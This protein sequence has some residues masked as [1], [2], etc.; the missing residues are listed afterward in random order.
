MQRNK[1]EKND[2]TIH[3][4]ARLAGVSSA[5]VSRYLNGGSLSAEKRAIIH[6]V[7]ESTGY[8]PD[9]T[10]Q[11]MRT[12]RVNQIGL[13][14]PRF[15]SSEV[16]QIMTGAANVLMQQGYFALMAGSA[17]EKDGEQGCVERMQRNHVAGILL[18]SPYASPEHESVYRSCRLPLV[19]VGQSLTDIATVRS[20]ER[21][22]ARELAERMLAAGRRSIAYIG[23]SERGNVSNENRRLG[24]QDALTAAGLD[25]AHMP[26]ISCGY[27]SYEEG[28][29][30]MELLLA[31]CPELDGVICSADPVALGAMRVL[32]AAGHAIGETVGLAGMGDSWANQAAE[33]PLASVKFYH[34][35]LGAEAANMLI[36][37]IESTDEEV[38]ARQ[39]TLGYTIVER[40]SL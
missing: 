32:K 37:Q 18:I 2:M 1:H 4:I 16:V 23:V 7:V 21:A 15:D 39:V 34:D 8:R 5:A 27:P 22:A 25:G 3:D 24:V 26:R 11:T 40:G 36:G 33:P 30:C 38:P 35:Q 29:R 28:V 9:T 19:V 6:A 12:G 31:R 17:H 13:V 10:A 14:A 20:D